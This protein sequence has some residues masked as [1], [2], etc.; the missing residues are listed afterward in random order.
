M[1]PLST[2]QTA[3]V[4]KGSQRPNDKM[5]HM[6]QGQLLKLLA[7]DPGNRQGAEV[8]QQVLNL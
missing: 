6:C 2:E 5:G 8:S 4:D 3:A 1:L 7:L